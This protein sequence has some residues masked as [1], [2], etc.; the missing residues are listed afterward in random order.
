MT[1]YD[2]QPANGTSCTASATISDP[3]QSGTGVYSAAVNLFLQN[4]GSVPIVVPYTVSTTASYVNVQYSWYASSLA[5]Q[6]LLYCPGSGS[7]LEMLADCVTSR[8]LS[9]CHQQAWLQ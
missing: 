8:K 5:E 6:T 1:C 7:T 4:T 3:W 9:G 2:V